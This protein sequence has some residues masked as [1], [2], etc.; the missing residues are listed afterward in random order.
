VPALRPVEG[1]PDAASDDDG[2]ATSLRVATMRLARR[3]RQQG[4]I[5]GLTPTQLATLGT[6]DRLGP[7]TLGELASKEKVQPPSMTRVVTALEA[8]GFVSRTIDPSDARV[9][10]VGVTDRGSEEMAEIRTRRDAWLEDRLRA[11]APADLAALERAVTVLEEL[12]ES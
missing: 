12:A 3:L 5:G 9:T 6:V 1:R 4:Q 11:M 2:L 7:L 8:L 10:R